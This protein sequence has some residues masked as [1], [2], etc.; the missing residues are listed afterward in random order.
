MSDHRM[1]PG[2]DRRT[3]TTQPGGLRGPR[4]AP[5]PPPAP[6][7]P[8]EPRGRRAKGGGGRDK[9]RILAWTSIALTGVIV[10]G[11]LTGYVVYR[12][13]WGSVNKKDV[14]KD[15]LNT[16]P[17][18]NSG[19]VNVL[20]V[21]SDTR[22]GEGNARYGQLDARRGAGKRTDTII[23][24]HISPNRDGAKLISFPRDSMVDIPRCKNETT[25]VVMAPKRDMINSAY[26]EGGIACTMSTLETL[27]GIR[28]HHF[29]EVDFSGFKNIVDAL[30]GIEVCLKSGVND[31]KSKLTLP[32]GKSLLDG[33][34]ALGFVRLR[35]YGD[36]SDIQRI[37]RQQLF[38]TKVVQ[39]ATSSDLLGN[40][41]RLTSLIK[42]AA[43]SV[44]MDEELAN[45]TQKLLD[46]AASAKAM[47]AGDVKFI[48]VPWGEDPADKNR[49]V[50]TQPDA[51]DLFN[52]IKNDVE[53]AEPQPSTTASAAPKVTP[54]PD[55]V[56][57]QV[58]NGTATPGKAREVADALTKEG[59]RVIGL[60]NFKAPEGSAKTQLRFGKRAVNGADYAAVV[61]K[62]MTPK[63]TA[64]QGGVKPL[65]TEPYT[66]TVPEG[67][68]PADGGKPPV[69][70][71]IV[72]DDFN[73][74]KVT[75]L[76]DS[77]A[78][79]TVSANQ[80]NV[81]T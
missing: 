76:P 54:K 57:I 81:C 75:K 52:A 33:E 63:V 34:K 5:P 44:T 18:N 50:W 79:N 16:R 74:V 6:P 14:D 42:A 66:S 37:R 43:Q 72:G 13:A 69:I 51:N 28:I 12:D 30:G 10:A 62:A 61:G 27:T 77:V 68:K 55:Q 39:K 45:D 49:V 11:S 21:G 32:P 59:F 25:G 46:I 67:A 71:L 2:Q 38:L 4:S 60:G 41:A 22:D 40:P 78:N 80:K 17:V 35:A 20:L 7:P 9:M 65:T 15:I 26:N 29:A 1:L 3:A 31:K 56:Q 24:M 64:T 58:L 70:Q 53:I 23:L 47:T 19:A 36:G 73:G 48:T 8:G